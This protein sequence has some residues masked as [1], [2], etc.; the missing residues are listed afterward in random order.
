MARLASL[1]LTLDLICLLFTTFAYMVT[2]DVDDI[3][4]V[5]SVIPN[6]SFLLEILLGLFC[7]YLFVYL[8]FC[9]TRFTR[10][11]F[12]FS[13]DF[14]F[15]E[16]LFLIAIL[17]ILLYL[18]NKETHIINLLNPSRAGIRHYFL[19]NHTFGFIN[20]VSSYTKAIWIYG[21]ISRYIDDHVN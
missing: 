13:S 4:R 15:Q 20:L 17:S 12:V 10:C 21:I 9:F 7:L 8:L 3:L 19:F 5:L 11:N 6:F 14:G 18:L 16:N 1:V 2:C